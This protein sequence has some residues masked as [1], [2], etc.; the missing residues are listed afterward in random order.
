M[1][2]GSVSLLWCGLLWAVVV[3]ACVIVRSATQFRGSAVFEMAFVLWLGRFWY[4]SDFRPH[5][6]GW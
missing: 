6:P 1:T 5:C 3:A 2:P 4:I